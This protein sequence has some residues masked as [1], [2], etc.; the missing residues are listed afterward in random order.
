MPSATLRQ[1]RRAEPDDEEFDRPAASRPWW[2]RLLLRRPLDT[3]AFLVLA[4][5]AS[6]IVVNGVY[7]QHGPH[8]APIFAVHPLP[9]AASRDSVGGVLQGS[10]LATPRHAAAELPHARPAAVPAPVAP[11]K[12]AI[13]ELL[14]EN[15]PPHPQPP[16]H[17]AAVPVPPPA[18]SLAQPS[19]QVLAVQRALSEF[20]Y[21][22]LKPT[23]ILDAETR[24]AVQRFERD[25]K[26]PVT[27]EISEAVKRE[28]A[29]LAGRDLN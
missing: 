23:G 29:S 20:G 26:L 4:G 13:A 21:G 14:A 22:Q 24:A 15:P 11:R 18:R 1:R 19:H 2:W 3:L 28:L 6:A 9:V 16:A 5:A 12:D 25:R 10:D 7:L 8:P 27:G 17:Q